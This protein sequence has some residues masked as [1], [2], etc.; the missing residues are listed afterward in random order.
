[1]GEII[2][3]RLARKARARTE[4]DQTA[5]ENRLK[6]GKTKSERQRGAL[7]SQQADNKLDGHR[8]VHRAENP[9]DE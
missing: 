2:N 1:M 3:L 4:K 8:L 6:F 5:G 9:V 7:E